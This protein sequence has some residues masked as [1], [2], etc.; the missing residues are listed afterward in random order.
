MQQFGSLLQSVLTGQ[1]PG[2]WRLLLLA[3]VLLLGACG[4]LEAPAG[5]AEPLSQVELLRQDPIEMARAEALYQGSCATF[6]HAVESGDGADLFD[7]EWTHGNSDDEIF[8]I[9]TEGI[10]DTRMVGFGANFPEGEA[11]TWRLVA[12]IRERQ[13]GCD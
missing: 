9:I 11:D 8:T 10:P 5:D 12:Y 1:S 7:C 3:N 13:P 2:R 6:C 4:E